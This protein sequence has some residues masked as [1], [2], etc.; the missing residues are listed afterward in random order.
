MINRL[1]LVLITL[2]L[3]WSSSLPAQIGETQAAEN[4]QELRQGI[5]IVRLPSQSK[6]LAALAA[7]AENSE[8]TETARERAKGQLEKAQA[9]AKAEATIIQAS[10]SNYFDYAPVL[11][12]Y[13]TATPKLTKGKRSG[14]FLDKNLETSS[15]VMDKESFFVLDIGFTDPANSSRSFA[16]IIKDR[17]YNSLQ[18]PFPYAQR[19]NTPALAFDQLMG[20]NSMEKYYRKAVIRLN[21]KLYRAVSRMERS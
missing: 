20:R 3:F 19:I 16:F 9:D 21:K 8:A 14:F 4:L 5:L 15:A 1:S 2:L 10:F 17:S 18:A 7:M 13:D 6:K 11:F 12:M